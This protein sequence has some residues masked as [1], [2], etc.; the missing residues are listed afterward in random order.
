MG[1]RLVD[2]LVAKGTHKEW[3]ENGHRYVSN[4]VITSGREE[5]TY[6]EKATHKV[7]SFWVS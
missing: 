2:K 3:E 6:G 7:V 5:G 4:R 1:K